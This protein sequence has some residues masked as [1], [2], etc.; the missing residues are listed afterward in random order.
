MDSDNVASFFL[1]MV[2]DNEADVELFRLIMKK[3]NMDVQFDT[4]GDGE[5]LIRFLKKEPPYENVPMPNLI[6]L[7]INM[8]RMNGIEALKYIKN[9]DSFK[10]IPVLMFTSSNR[11]ED[12]ITCYKEHA[13][14]YILKP[15]QIEEFI[16]IITTLKEYW[17]ETIQLPN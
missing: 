6:L 5:K 8:P 15:F 16:K 10:M 3:A 17:M 7:D 12:I 2:D 1:L 13:N 14:A 4:V 9:N 11:K